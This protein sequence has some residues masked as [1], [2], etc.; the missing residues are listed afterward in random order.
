MIHM[1]HLES[2][3]ETG[4]NCNI[5]ICSFRTIWIDSNTDTS[6]SLFHFLASPSPYFHKFFPGNEQSNI[7]ILLQSNPGFELTRFLQ[8]TS[9]FDR[10][11]IGF[12]ADR[13]WLFTLYGAN[14]GHWTRLGAAGRR[15]AKGGRTDDILVSTATTNTMK[16]LSSAPTGFSCSGMNICVV[17]CHLE[18]L[19]LK[20]WDMEPIRTIES[21]LF[22]IAQ[23][24]T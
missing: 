12:T 17:L 7:H 23:T 5:W 14:V 4:F 13:Q 24:N 9:N 20:W 22:S 16:T 15:P 11:L 21:V 8:H 10:P 18:L 1:I 6:S 19:Q 3:C 2:A